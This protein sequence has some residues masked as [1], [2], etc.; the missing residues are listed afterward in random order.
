MILQNLKKSRNALWLCN[1]RSDEMLF[2]ELT[3]ICWL[4][5]KDFK[6]RGGAFYI[7]LML[8]FLDWK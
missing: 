5:T 1:V 2:V 3:F 6:V 8:S 7:F 4:T